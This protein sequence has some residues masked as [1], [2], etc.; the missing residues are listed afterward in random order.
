MNRR[1]ECESKRSVYPCSTVVVS[2]R[3]AAFENLPK[4][5]VSYARQRMSH[6]FAAVPFFGARCYFVYV[7]IVLALLLCVNPFIEYYQQYGIAPYNAILFGVA[8]LFGLVVVVALVDVWFAGER[9]EEYRRQRGDRRRWLGDLRVFSFLIF[10]GGV[11]LFAIQM[12]IVYG[13]WFKTGWDIFEI[14]HPELAHLDPAYFST[15][16]NQWFITG[17]FSVVTNVAHF[18]NIDQYLL[19]V[20]GSC[21]SVA[22]SVVLASFV[23]RAIGG[24]FVGLSTFAVSFVLCGLSPNILI[25]YT[26]SYGMLCPTVT[27]FFYAVVKKPWL[28]VSG[29]VFFGY[30]GY[31]IKPT[32]IFIVAAV[33]V[34]ELCRLFSKILG[35]CL[36][37][38]NMRSVAGPFMGGILSFVLA[39]SLASFFESRVVFDNDESK[40]FNAAHYLMMGFNQET[41]GVY[42]Q[43]DF[44]FSSGF[45]NVSDRTTGNLDVWSDRV[46][47]AGVS[48]V[49]RL[50][51][52]KACLS[53][54]EGAFTWRD[55]YFEDVYGQNVLFKWLY[56]IPDEGDTPLKLAPDDVVPWAYFAQVVW[57]FVLLGIASSLF[58][59]KIPSRIAVIAIAL[60]MTSVFLL[61]FECRARYLFLYAPCFVIAGMYGW[62]S[63]SRYIDRRFSAGKR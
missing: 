6:I 61:L 32:G 63:I 31:C 12:A 23:G 37:R 52:E 33:A 2:S 22:I 35:G 51:V 55:W 44:A 16:P 57:F 38:V 20:I 15:Y 48:G 25:P 14:T 47:E 8:V 49:T 41:N 7:A 4:K 3:S 53:Y 62:M 1:N 56:G 36:G 46:H 60:F 19:F 45:D 42:S 30:I 50:L 18:F 39:F 9:E 40:A 43:D 17:F 21:A 29:V 59:R 54:G 10:S 11:A 58:A 13:C 34:V 26:D 27:L 24:T 5:G 28:R